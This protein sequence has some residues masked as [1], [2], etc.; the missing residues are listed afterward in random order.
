MKDSNRPTRPRPQAPS[1]RS[2]SLGERLETEAREVPAPGN[3]GLVAQ[4]MRN[5]RA[6]PRRTESLALER[7][8]GWFPWI[9]AGV[10]AAVVA[11]T[12]AVTTVS[13]QSTAPSLPRYADVP[14]I[15][16]SNLDPVLA[17]REQDLAGEM[18]RIRADLNSIARLVSLRLEADT[19]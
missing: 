11:I 10:T 4:V 3:S 19:Q 15:V 2:V 9:M 7:Q 14:R 5:V 8:V 16:G 12:I 6:A 1:H 17:S 18:Q 13:E